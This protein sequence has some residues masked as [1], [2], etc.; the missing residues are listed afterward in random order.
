MRFSGVRIAVFFFAVG[1]SQ[2]QKGLCLLA[3]FLKMPP[4]GNKKAPA[5]SHENRCLERC[6][7]LEAE[8]YHFP[9]LILPPIRITENTAT[10]ITAEIHM[11]EST[12]IQLHLITPNSFS[13]IKTIVRTD[14]MPSPPC[15]ALL[16]ILFLKN[17]FHNFCKLRRR[18]VKK[19]AYTVNFSRQNTDAD[20]RAD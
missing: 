19:H 10:T 14:T 8:R 4:F 16:S 12:H 6:S 15:F 9:F 13:T 5:F 18:A 11:G 2:K 1:D 3:C 20:G 17:L 7:A